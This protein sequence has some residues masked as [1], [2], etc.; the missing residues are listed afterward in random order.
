MRPSRSIE[1][2]LDN[3]MLS[4][5]MVIIVNIFF[6]KLQIYWVTYMYDV[7]YFP[8]QSHVKTGRWRLREVK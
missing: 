7:T 8:Q 2:S 3:W 4:T 1:L 5:L 6:E